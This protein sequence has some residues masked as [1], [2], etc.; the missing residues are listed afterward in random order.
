MS[1]LRWT[2]RTSEIGFS[3]TSD[4]MASRHTTIIH[5]Q[6]FWNFAASK[7]VC[8][9]TIENV[10]IALFLVAW[11]CL[12]CVRVVTH[13]VTSHCKLLN[14]T[15]DFAATSSIHCDGSATIWP[16]L[17][18]M[19]R[20]IY[21]KRMFPPRLELRTFRVLGERD[22]HYTTETAPLHRIH[23]CLTYTV[24]SKGVESVPFFRQT[25]VN[26]THENHEPLW[27]SHDG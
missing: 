1:S 15:V 6:L 17:C 20:D 7:P 2:N 14:F 10:C 8:F 24:S 19:A 12:C 13:G 9:P 21:A 4:Y 27:C 3:L 5:V 23:H 11:Q 22:N 18:K 16:N 25:Q 26:L